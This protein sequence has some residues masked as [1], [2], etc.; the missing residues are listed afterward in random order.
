MVR[1][2]AWKVR[3]SFLLPIFLVSFVTT[4]AYPDALDPQF[5]AFLE[6]NP[7][8]DHI[9]CAYTRT[10]ASKESGTR[11][12]RYSPE[13]EWR[14]LTVEGNEPTERELAVYA[15]DAGERNRRRNSPTDLEFLTRVPLGPIQVNHRNEQT[16]E[17]V[18]SPEMGGEMPDKMEEK[19]IGR[20]TVTKDGLRPLK[21]E[22]SLDEPVSPMRG[23]K[24]REFMQETTFTTDHRTGATLL[25]SMKFEVGGRAFLVTKIDQ[26]EQVE[27]SDF[28][29][30]VVAEM[31]PES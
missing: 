4:P 3:R 25:K 22:V 17:F 29:C 20:L 1:I 8:Q 9:A 27:F 5:V 19:L 14:L 30:K 10:H 24:L 13:T 16:I 6:A 28:D 18:F 2:N 26:R 15:K 31:S 21:F 11:V 23:V 12:D 7:P